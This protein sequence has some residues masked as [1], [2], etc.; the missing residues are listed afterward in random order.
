MLGNALINHDFPILPV[1]VRERQAGTLVLAEPGDQD[2]IL[3]I[4]SRLGAGVQELHNFIIG[5]GPPF[6]GMLMPQR[7]QAGQRTEADKVALNASRPSKA[8]RP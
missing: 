3:D 7:L 6:L 5:Q 1:D 8:G 4:A 2:R